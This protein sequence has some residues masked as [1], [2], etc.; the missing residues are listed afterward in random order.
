MGD[1]SPVPGPGFR[2]FGGS[3][4]LGLQA[5]SSS[6]ESVPATE[7]DAG[8]VASASS[9]GGSRGGQ[10]QSQGVKRSHD[11]EGIR[12]LLD[13]ARGSGGGGWNLG[14][15]SWAGEGNLGRAPVPMDARS[16]ARTLLESLLA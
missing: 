10:S 13:S 2:S 15:D 7:V 9:G 16:E 8:S 5:S 4:G 14:C 11:G 1:P 3:A 12:H 6:L